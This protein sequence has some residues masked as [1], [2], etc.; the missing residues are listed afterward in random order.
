MYV[1]KKRYIFRKA[2]ARDIRRGI[3]KGIDFD[4]YRRCRWIGG[5]VPADSPVCFELFNFRLYASV[6][7][8]VFLV[9]RLLLDSCK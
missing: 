4:T 9:Y 5:G 3:D 1:E 7:E 6:R 8:P 2:F